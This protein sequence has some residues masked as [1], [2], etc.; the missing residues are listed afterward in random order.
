M[1]R[2]VLIAMILINFPCA[3][4]LDESRSDI[5]SFVVHVPPQ[6]EVRHESTHS[7]T[8]V[9]ITSGTPVMILNS[10][11][12]DDLHDVIPDDSVNPTFV[13]VTRAAETFNVRYDETASQE[14]MTLL[15]IPM[16]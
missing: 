6:L 9:K 7:A 16:L 5:Q 3:F 13:G 14:A 15:I 8:V 2:L 4:A 12:P 1:R 10:F 11:R